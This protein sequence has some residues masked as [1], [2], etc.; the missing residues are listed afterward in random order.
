MTTSS[1]RRRSQPR[2]QWQFETILLSLDKSKLG[3]YLSRFRAMSPLEV[4]WRLEDQAKKWAWR[5]LQVTGTAGHPDRRPAPPNPAPVLRAPV[6]RLRFLATLP[7]GA[8]LEVPPKARHAVIATADELLAGRWVLLGVERKDIEDPDWF[9]DP[10]TGTNA[11][12]S[13]YCFSI[14][15]RS[16]RVTGNIKQVWE[17]SRLQHVTVLAAAFALSGDERYA[18]RAAHHLRSWWAKNPFLSGVHWT[19]GIELGLRL[20]SWVWVRRLMEGWAGTGELFEGNRDAL[21]QIWWHQR[22]LARFHGRGSSANNHVIAEAAGQLVASLAFDWFEE[23]GRWARQARV[24]LEQELVKNT[25]PSGVNREMASEYHGFVAELGLLAATEADRAGQPLSR[26]TWHVLRRMTDVVAATSDGKVHAPRQGDG[27]DGKALLLG[28]PEANRWESLLAL[29]ARLFGAP[30][31]WPPSEP[32]ATSTLV[33]SIA[34]EHR[35]F[36]TSARRPC[37]FADAGLT[38]LRTNQVEGPEIWCRCDAGPH[39]FLSI[40][41]HA[42]AD[43]LS[44][45]VRHDGT[46][47][48]A[49]PGTYCYHVEPAWRRYFRSTLGHN[50]VEIAHLDQSEPGGPTMWARHASSRLVELGFD[51]RGEANVWT[52]EHDGYSVLDPPAQHRR[53]VRLLGRERRVD[54]LDVVETPVPRAIRIAFHLG[55]DVKA[56]LAT[57][58]LVQ[59]HWL[60][61]DEE[62]VTASLQLPNGPVWSV[63]RGATNPILGWYSARFGEKQPSTTIVGEGTADGRA[64]LPTTLQFSS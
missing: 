16:E 9:L 8:L 17:L 39:G 38:I 44:I 47:V 53:T 50:T 22:Y 15:Y 62:R 24:L 14:N 61:Q 11:P 29:G 37:H 49:D 58:N 13:A 3:W 28:P 36:P 10:A 42:H 20:I 4:A 34:S 40:A 35:D 21:S 7:E 12:R 64:E 51:E 43:A 23:S 59:L 57:S 45:E 33:A 5:P 19:S 1:R 52:A 55:P 2:Q 6:G 32:D 63:W 41:A 31:W 56:E 25:F 54:V 18:Q 26:G 46:E 48:L 27:D 30:D 60:N